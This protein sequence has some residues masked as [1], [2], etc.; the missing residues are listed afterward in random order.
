[1]G[2]TPH[3]LLTSVALVWTSCSA[4]PQAVLPA[5][6]SEGFVLGPEDVFALRV[7]GEED[8]S[9]SYRVEAD[10]TIDFPFIGQTH[11]AGQQPNDVA[12][13]V[14]RRLLEEEILRA[15]Q[16]SVYV[17]EYASKRISVVGAVA[18]PGTFPMTA[19]LTVVQ[20]ISLAGG[21]K[22]AS[23]NSTVLTR[24]VDGELRRFSVRANDITRGRA[25]DVPVQS[26][27]IIFVP[28]SAF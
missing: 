19:G 15:P 2:W 9:G 22:D 27:D 12:N 26:G 20:A 10:G 16:V 7:Y 3:L 14:E 1:M 8:L 25:A 4:T 23:S 24:R 21:F 28:G 13:L 5:D 6:S 17:L 11:V 18:S